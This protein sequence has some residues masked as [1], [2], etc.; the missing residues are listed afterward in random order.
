MH[1]GKIHLSVTETCALCKYVWN[2]KQ[3]LKSHIKRLHKG[4]EYA[5]K[6]STKLHLRQHVK[7]VHDGFKYGC[8]SCDYKSGDKGNLNKHIEKKHFLDD[9]HFHDL[10][11]E[12]L[13]VI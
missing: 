1:F 11:H 9:Y 4:V 5:Y 7:N 3:L 12:H 2:F 6:A 8:T 13:G 10:F